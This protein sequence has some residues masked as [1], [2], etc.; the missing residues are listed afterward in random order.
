MNIHEY[1]VN[2]KLCFFSLFHTFLSFHSW[3]N[4][5]F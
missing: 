1:F 5:I 2:V 4:M 3:M